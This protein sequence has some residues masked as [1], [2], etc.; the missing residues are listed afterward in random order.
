MVSLD[1]RFFAFF[2]VFSDDFGFLYSRS[3]PDLLLFLNYFLSDG[4]WAPFR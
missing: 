1:C 2:G 4:Q 3:V